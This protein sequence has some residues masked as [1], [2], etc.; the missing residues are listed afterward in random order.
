MICRHEP[1]SKALS[2]SE[3][4]HLFMRMKTEQTSSSRNFRRHAR[5]IIE[6]QRE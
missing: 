2:Q 5:K 1:E 6:R 4:R 3:K